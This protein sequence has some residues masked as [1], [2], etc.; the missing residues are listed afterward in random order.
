MRIFIKYDQ[1]GKIISVSK[2]DLMPEELENPYGDLAANEQVLE[3]TETEE[4][5]QI[6]AIQIHTNYRVDT[7]RKKLV[8]RS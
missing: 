2:V 1:E 7:Q 4:I 5:A 3:V 8:S 6:D